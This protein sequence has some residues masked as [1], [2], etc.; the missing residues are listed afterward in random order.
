MTSYCTLFVCDVVAYTQLPKLIGGAEARSRIVQL[1]EGSEKYSACYTRPASTVPLGESML[2]ECPT[3]AETGI[4]MKDETRGAQ[5][6][7]R[8]ALWE[9]ES[10]VPSASEAAGTYRL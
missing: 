9:K 5:R 6:R 4:T 1:T 10:E 7:L 8:R 2:S 3:S